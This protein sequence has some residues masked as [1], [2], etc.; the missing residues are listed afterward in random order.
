MLDFYGHRVP[1]GWRLLA[2]IAIFLIVAIVDSNVP[3]WS[4]ATDGILILLF[5]PF[6]LLNFAFGTGG[7]KGEW[8]WKISAFI[9]TIVTIAYSPSSSFGYGMRLACTLLVIWT[10]IFATFWDTFRRRASHL[11]YDVTYGSI[12]VLSLVVSIFIP[13]IPG[14]GIPVSLKKLDWNFILPVEVIFYTVCGLRYGIL[15]DLVEGTRGYGKGGGSSGG[16]GGSGGSGDGGGSGS[17]KKEAPPARIV[18]EAARCAAG[19]D[20]NVVLVGVKKSLGGYYTIVL[21]HLKTSVFNDVVE[22][23]CR[24]EGNMHIEYKGY[25]PSYVRYSFTYH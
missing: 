13:E 2:A 19:A 23:R 10:L 9:M 24:A 18:E 3:T 14:F 7:D 16:G 6:L 1:W 12:L 4:G 25:D 8:I 11:V 22:D 15:F 21:R 20:S 17:S 5:I